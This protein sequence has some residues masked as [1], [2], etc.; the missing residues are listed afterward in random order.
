MKIDRQQF[1]Q[2]IKLREYIRKAIRVIRE[3]KEKEQQ[4]ILEAENR[5]RIIV[6]KLLKEEG[7]GD[8]S[9]GIAF[10]RRDLKK[11]LPELEDTYTSLRTSPDQRKSYRVHIS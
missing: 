10:L 6:R 7:E 1:L 8:E 5:L 4:Q 11:I 3:R 9:T 2:E